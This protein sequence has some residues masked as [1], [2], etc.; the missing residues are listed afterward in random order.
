MCCL[1]KGW[2]SITF[3]VIDQ[4]PGCILQVCWNIAG[5]AWPYIV[6]GGWYCWYSWYWWC[7]RSQASWRLSSAQG[8]CFSSNIFIFFSGRYC[9][10]VK[11]LWC[12]S[13]STVVPR[14][15]IGVPY[16]SFFCINLR[17]WKLKKK[18]PLV[19]DCQG[20]KEKPPIVT[21]SFDLDSVI[22]VDF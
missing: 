14:F 21:E 8:L 5:R 9:L 20:T 17:S 7:Q 11:I 22:L 12:I 3:N 2:L 6:K 18:L 1:L 13:K 10:S 4:S 15:L 19:F 16:L